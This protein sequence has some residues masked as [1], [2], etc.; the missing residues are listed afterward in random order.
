MAVSAGFSEKL[1]QHPEAGSEAALARIALGK[2]RIQSV[3]DRETVAHYRT[4]E[5]KISDQG[6]EGQLVDPHLLGLAVMDMLEQNRLRSVNHPGSGKAPWYTNLTTKDEAIAKRLD[7]L[8]PLYQSVSGGGFGNLTGDALEVVVFQ[9][10][11]SI[12]A[13]NKRFAY[14]GHFYLDK[15]KNEHGRFVKLQ[16]PKGVGGGITTKKADFIQFGHSAGPLCIECK[17]Y[18]EWLYP[19]SQLIKDTILKAYELESVPVL[20]ARRIHYSA[21]SNFLA[22][23]GIIAHESFN[24]YY[25]SDQAELAEKVSHK[26]SLGFTDVIATETPHKRTR[27]FFE[28]TLPSIVDAMGDRWNSNKDALFEYAKGEL[29]LAQLYTAI[30]SP[31]GGKWNDPPTDFEF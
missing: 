24:Q 22:P 8:A 5:Q 6:P 16:P 13:A 3:L 7:V 29:N 28:K 9:V 17:N 12:F 21:M 30:G 23:A 14:Q 1:L 25:P 4:L 20:V 15:P 31:A 11:R 26:R 27:V 2:K 18:R 19:G 10:L